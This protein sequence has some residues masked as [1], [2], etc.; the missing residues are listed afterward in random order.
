MCLLLRDINCRDGIHELQYE[1]M[2]RN[3]FLGGI[4]IT[5]PKFYENESFTKGIF[6]IPIRKKRLNNN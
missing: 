4:I 1:T 5:V 3:V 6:P 2:F